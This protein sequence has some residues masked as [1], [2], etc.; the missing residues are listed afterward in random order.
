MSV[1]R[2]GLQLAVLGFAAFVTSFG[3]HV[4]AVNLLVYA[5]QVGVGTLFIGLLIAI[6]DFAEVGAKSVF[7]IVADRRGL[8]AIFLAGIVLFS[9]ASLSF[10]GLPPR[11]LLLVRF[12]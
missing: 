7:G 10:L 11:L 6:Y 4:V 3:A 1:L 2:P 12:F 8:K 5:K 9:L